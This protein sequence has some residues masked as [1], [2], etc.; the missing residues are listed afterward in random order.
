VT[1][2]EHWTHPLI[3]KFAGISDPVDWVT[4]RARELV[5]QAVLKGWGPPFDPL[6]LA[7][8]L[9]LKVVPS[10]DIRDART[11]AA[12]SSNCRIEFNPNR[13]RGR[14]RHSIAHQISHTLFSERSD[15]PS[16]DSARA[17]QRDDNWQV[18]A[19]C[20]IADAEFLIP[21]GSLSGL[22]THDTRV[23][24]L[25]DS[26][27][28][29]GISVEAVLVRFARGS[30]RSCAMFCASRIEHGPKLG[31]Y[32]LDY[33]IGSRTWHNPIGPGKL[34]PIQS[35]VSE[36]TA[37]GHTVHGVERWPGVKPILA[38]CV[39]VAPYPERSFPRVIGICRM[40]GVQSISPLIDAPDTNAAGISGRVLW[41]GRG[42]ST[43]SR[44]EA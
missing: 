32:R 31:R 43:E 38:E 11:V 34:L 5:A 36:C 10:D 28:R 39:G 16:P 14:I 2:P 21:L 20:N 8:H 37:I 26:G 42:D 4:E 6:T 12:G 13:P 35:V 40:D 19:L 25:V 41:A 23:A 22:D 1:K 3:L 18:E 30:G 17:G 15:R 29:S 44:I 9:G 24:Q 27:H 7:D 33:V